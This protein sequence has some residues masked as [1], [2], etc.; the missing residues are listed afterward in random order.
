MTVFRSGS[1]TGLDL[2]LQVA[3]EGDLGGALARE[4]RRLARAARRAAELA[5]RTVQ[6]E[7][8][9]DVYAAGFSN[10]RRLAN[11][12]RLRVFP[13]PGV[14]TLEPAVWVFSSADQIVEAF[15]NGVTIRANQRRFLAIP[16]PNA[17]VRS[18]NANRDPRRRGQTLV[19]LAEQRFG[20][21]RFVPTRRGG[22]LVARLR[23]RTG[24][25][26]GF[27]R[28]TARSLARGETQDVV[29]FVLVPEVRL[30]RLLRGA[31]IRRRARSVF[32][33]RFQTFF[34]AELAA[35]AGAELGR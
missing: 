21:L 6:L 29:L 3:L 12:W 13:R 34:E 15:E 26:G 33:A 16:T 28:P 14:E 5:G 35:S 7:L 4:Q 24:A 17:P 18:R 25:R 19:Q 20:P 30:P 1:A 31:A 8:R 22:L 23:A 2:Q 11:T 27:A 32:P 9:A 10:P